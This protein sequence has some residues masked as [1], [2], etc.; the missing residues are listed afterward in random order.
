[1]AVSDC[2][3]AVP[4]EGGFWYNLFTA[5]FVPRL[6][7]VGARGEIV[8]LHIASDGAIALAYYSIPVA[9]ACFLRW[10]R[11]LSF[12]W[13]FWLFAAFILACGT[14][15]V[16]SIV[17]F[18]HPMYCL[19]G[20]IKALTGVISLVTA[21]LLW[22]LVGRA[23]LLPSPAQLR[24]A[25]KA[26]SLEIGE[27]RSVETA[28]QKAKSDLESRVDARTAELAHANESLAI[29]RTRAEQKLA[30]ISTLYTT[31][32]EGLFFVDPTLRLLR[33]NERFAAMFGH[34]SGEFLGLTLKEAIPEIAT[35]D[36]SE[37]MRCVNE[38]LQHGMPVAGRAVYP[39]TGRA[40]RWLMSASPVR[41]A[42][43]AILG[44]NVVLQD[45]TEQMELED[46]LRQS[47]KSEAIGQLASGIAHEIN[48]ALTAIYGY[49]SLG[50]ASVT[51]NH[52]AASYLD[53]ILVAA[54][55]ASSVTKSLLTFA[56]R[57]RTMKE[58]VRV[59]DVV[60]RSTSLLS[61]LLPANIR[62]VAD[63][64]NAPD[65]VVLGDANQLQQVVLNLAINSRDAMPK[66]GMLSISLAAGEQIG[67]ADKVRLTVSDTGEGMSAEVM[68][69]MFEPFFTTKARGQGTGLGM[70]V[71]QGI[72]RSHDA[73]IRV[74][75]KLGEGTTFEIDLPLAS[76]TPV[77][78]TT[79]VTQGDAPTG[80]GAV[81]I[82]EDNRA[83]RRILADG[84][85]RYGYNVIEA[86]DG[87][88]FMD[89]MAALVT[90][91]A[92]PAAIV[93]DIDM[94][95]KSGLDCLAALRAQ[96]DLTPAVVISGGA[97]GNFD[98]KRVIVLPKPFQVRD[99]AEAIAAAGRMP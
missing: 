14:T 13:M 78:D 75:S 20:V 6:D 5:D 74:R 22:P 79:P 36:S 50:R 69:R 63:T 87:A 84:L 39:A 99:L 59:A 60:D 1:M 43:G 96:G 37:F 66:G 31:A 26:L 19:D 42:T 24:D 44:A 48:N 68:E 92:R 61:G 95:I 64:T 94:P 58:N 98:H 45:V 12:R 70:S 83:V 90:V 91:G 52:P 55:Q 23:L 28:L 76:T 18:W 32:P 85:R 4:A 33:V 73:T 34:T 62:M 93:L 46:Q 27:R 57:E 11:D 81:V 29:S 89:H 9:L 40:R 21:V 3:M 25:N 41:S 53:Q 38:V 7:C 77:Q 56:R 10:R 30:E 2:V 67:A 72:V 15:H 82:A 51:N 88:E 17:A 8:W 97:I 47:Q 35:D 86:D 65:A 49:L 71:V 80:S 16:M 54:Q